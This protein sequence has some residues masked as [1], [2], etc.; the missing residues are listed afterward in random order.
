MNHKPLVAKIFYSS[1]LI[2]NHV[3]VSKKKNHVFYLLM[4]IW[5]FID[6]KKLCISRILSKKI[7]LYFYLFKITCVCIISRWNI[8]TLRDEAKIMQTR[9]CANT[10]LASEQTWE[11]S[12]LVFGMKNVVRYLN[13][14]DPSER[15]ACVA[16]LCFEAEVRIRDPVYGTVCIIHCLQRPHQH[17][18]LSLK[19]A[20]REL[21]KIKHGQNH[22]HLLTRSRLWVHLSTAFVRQK[23]VLF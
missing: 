13:E 10:L 17:L 23:K 11:V 5:C 12:L 7:L 22:R 1:S 19:M 9:V 15:Q 20:R 3:S 6:F 16:S 18:Q 4:V 8:G 2:L 14:I 21:A